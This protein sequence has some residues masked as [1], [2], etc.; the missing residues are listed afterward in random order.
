ML[1]KE[2]IDGESKKRTQVQGA[3]LYKMPDLRPAKGVHKEIRCLPYMLPGHG[4]QGG[5]A[6]SDQV[7]LVMN[8]GSLPALPRGEAS[9]N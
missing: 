4:P 3:G 5:V 7:K 2:I 6:W 9:R 8:S 1:G